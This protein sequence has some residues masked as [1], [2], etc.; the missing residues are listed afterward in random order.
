MP[1]RPKTKLPTHYSISADHLIALEHALSNL[2]I[3]PEAKKQIMA[4]FVPM[5]NEPQPMQMTKQNFDA[6]CQLVKLVHQRVINSR[7][8]IPVLADMC[9]AG[10]L[11][12]SDTSRRGERPRVLLTDV[13]VDIL[14][15]A[16]SLPPP[17]D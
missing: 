1:A 7:I 16:R 10:L 17:E 15:Y 2:R 11:I 14:D 8:A 3:A 12:K 5:P 6:M 13:L 9:A 4:S